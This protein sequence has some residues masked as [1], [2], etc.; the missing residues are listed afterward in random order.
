[1]PEAIFE[2]TFLDPAAIAAR[3]TAKVPALRKVGTAR[4]LANATVETVQAPTAWVVIM[5][6]AASDVRYEVCDVIEQLV[7]VRFGVIL[8][9]RDIADRTGTAARE[10]LKQIR[11]EVLKALGSWM[12]E[13]A[14]HNCRFSRGAL[15]SGIG[16][17]GM[18]FWQDE[19]TIGFDRRTILEA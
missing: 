9:V 19:F 6:E 8:A 10:D 11:I 16:R 17:D 1:M 5:S 3:L 7:T 13:G 4:D 15:T 14:N 2:Q 18:M 12:P